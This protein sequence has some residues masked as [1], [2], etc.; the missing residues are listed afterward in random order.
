ML[1]L[2]PPAILTPDKRCWTAAELFSESRSCW[3]MKAQPQP[4]FQKKPAKPFFFTGWKSW[5]GHPFFH[6]KK[7]RF[8]GGVQ[9]KLGWLS[10]SRQAG[11]PVTPDFFFKPISRWFKVPFSPPSWRSLNPLRGSLKHP[12]KV[13]LNHQA[14]EFWGWFCAKNAYQVR[15]QQ[16]NCQENIV[17]QYA[18][19]IIDSYDWPPFFNRLVSEFHQRPLNTWSELQ[20]F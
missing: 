19:D 20:C 12:K 6:G 16:Q 17:F 18:C 14:I 1:D 4:L 15:G 9:L 10:S 13:T 5:I 8:I 2:K 7:M 3:F 11:L